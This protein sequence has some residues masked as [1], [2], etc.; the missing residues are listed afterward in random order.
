VD[1]HR[2]GRGYDLL[3]P[4]ACL[5]RKRAPERSIH[6]GVVDDRGWPRWMHDAGSLRLDGWRNVLQRRLAAAR[7]EPSLEHAAATATT[8]ADKF[9]CL[10]HTRPV[11]GDGRRHLL[12]RW[13]AA[14]GRRASFG[15]ARVNAAAA[16]AATAA[17]AAAERQQHRMH[18][19]GSVQ[20]HGRRHLL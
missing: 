17:T 8:P 12:Q 20:R 10:H 7:H 11:R 4:C 3:V 14:A 5:R 6:T 1:A 16:T 15:R 18:D 2:R 13:L 19:A 9:G